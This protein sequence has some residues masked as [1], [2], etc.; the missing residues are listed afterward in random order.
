MPIKPIISALACA[1]LCLSNTTACAKPPAPKPTAATKPAMWALSDADTTIYLFGT[2]HVL[3]KD[4]PWRTKA[5][6]KAAAQADTLVLEVADL[7]DQA[8]T[9]AV[10]TRLATSPGLPPVLDRVPSDKRDGMAALI[11]KS[12]FSIA[13]L[14]PFES[15]AV[16]I[17]LA[18]GALRELDLSPDDGVERNLTAEFTAAKKPILALES[19]ELQLGFFDQLSERAQ[20]DFLAG[21]VDDQAD[22]RG[23]FDAMLGAWSKGD[24]KAIAASFDDELRQTPELADGLIRKRNANWTAW[25]IKRL[26]TP[27]TVLVAVGAGHLAGGDSVQVM[28]AK[29]GLKVKR[30]Q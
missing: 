13:A 5:F 7:E 19:S 1:L 14:T 22:P 23:E 12:G 15:W 11:K 4:Y 20:R 26:D 18:G 9:A 27:G 8:K 24:D 2:I 30:V 6:N 21:L 17:T 10:F 28:L 16:A 29:Q 25:L 3:P